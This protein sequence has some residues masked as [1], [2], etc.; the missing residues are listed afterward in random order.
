MIVYRD[1]CSRA[2]PHGLLLQL[3]SVASHSCISALDHDDAVDLVIESGVLESA[4]ADSL[5]PDIDGIHPLAQSLRHASVMAGHVFWHTWQ[6]NHQQARQWSARL[7]M[8]LREVPDHELPRTVQVSV[9][10]GYAYYAVYPE[11][12]LEAAK[13]FY[14]QTGLC[15][16]VCLGIRS[17]GTSLSA[18]VVAT[19]EELG[20]RVSSF[21]VR[22]RGHPFSRRPLLSEELAARLRE[23]PTAYFLLT[24]E[25]PGISGSS[26]AGTAAMLQSWGIDGDHIVLF[27]SWQ[28]DGAHLA[29]QEARQQWRQ[30]PRLT[31]SFEEVWLHSG[32]LGSTFPGDL[33]DLS[34]GAWRQELY[35]NVAEY[36]A[37]QPQHERRKY[38]LT[39]SGTP[40]GA[41]LLSFAGLGQRSLK[42]VERLAR[43]A[44]AGFTVGPERVA[45]GFLLRPFVAGTP[46]STALIDAELLERAA[47]YL[48]HLSQEHA[49]EASVHD[50]SLREMITM[51][52]AEGLQLPFEARLREVLPAS[53]WVERPVALDGRMLV[54]EWVRTPQGILK[55]DAMDHHDDHFFPGCQDIAWDVAAAVFELDLEAR[56]RSHLVARYRRLSGDRGITRRL[57]HY[58]IAYLSFRLGY[59]T[60][61][62][63]VLGQTADGVRFTGQA[64]RYAR[65]LASELNTSPAQWND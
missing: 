57:H 47:A 29:S 63:S 7:M 15:D 35:R 9:P 39:A 26:L 19:L 2:D 13:R 40:D 28:T 17:I 37:V 42:K 23:K 3:R 53:G 14:T 52:V 22:P 31:A 25:G 10:E 49:T 46:A 59:A 62:T 11:M 20:C 1:Q 61:A 16:A 51:N 27:P 55:L 44:E 64:K 5:F 34:A 18:V 36:P 54:H 12:Y 60:L 38:L 8:A 32:R 58:A 24:D 43:L 41:R 6:G 56:S 4:I 45:H 33:R 50:E 21:T 48:A 30:H 65:L